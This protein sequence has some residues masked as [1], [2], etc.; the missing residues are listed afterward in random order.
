MLISYYLEV[1]LLLAESFIS[2][3]PLVGPLI[4]QVLSWD[5]APPNITSH[6]YAYRI[7]VKSKRVR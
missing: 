3:R 1:L 6:V 4:V 5:S 2:D 7:G